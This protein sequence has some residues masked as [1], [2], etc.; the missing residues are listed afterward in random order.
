MEKCKD[1]GA[2]LVSGKCPDCEARNQVV[3]MV[4]GLQVSMTAQLEDQAKQLKAIKDQNDEVTKQNDELAKKVNRITVVSEGV[5]SDPMAGYKNYQE[6]LN[7]VMLAGKSESVPAR[8]AKAQEVLKNRRLNTVG[9]DEHTMEDNTTGGFLIPGMTMPGVKTKDPNMLQLNTGNYTQKLPIP[10]GGA[11]VNYR[12]DEDHSTS[13]T[14]GIQVY[15]EKEAKQFTSSR[16]QLKQVD[17]DPNMLIGMSFASE[18]LVTAAPATFIALIK[19]SFGDEYVS[20]LNESRIWG[21]GTGEYK[22]VMTSAA[23][24]AVPKE[25]SQTKETINGDNLV[26]MKVRCWGYNQSIW[27]ANQDTEPDLIKSHI[28]RTNSDVTYMYNPDNKTILGRPVFFDENCA[29]IGTE[30]DIILVNWLEY[31]EGMVGSTTFDESIHLR[32]DYG[33]RAFRTISYVAGAP[34]WQ[35]PVTPKRSTM[36]FSPFITLAVRA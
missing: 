16:T 9:S 29:T 1:C 11:K 26:N 32:F 18:K 19:N 2:E 10:M 6:Y 21:T 36:T 28:A 4:N 12:V 3:N 24:I 7:D 8:L 17:L 35:V 22:G 23:K 33:E 14:G 20:T 30:G 15:W 34:A 31:Y 13:V 5:D 27:L 25:G